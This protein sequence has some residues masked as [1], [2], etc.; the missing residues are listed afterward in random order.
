MESTARCLASA[1]DYVDHAHV[2]WWRT[3]WLDCHAGGLSQDPQS[4]IP[5]EGCSGVGVE[6]RLVR[7]VVGL[8]EQIDSLWRVRKHS[9]AHAR[10]HEAYAVLT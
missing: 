9:P 6:C 8:V 7:S 4:L 5:D 10:S 2:G 3:G 1:G